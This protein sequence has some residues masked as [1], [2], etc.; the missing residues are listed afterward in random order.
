AK[1]VIA[2]RK[3]RPKAAALV[4]QVNKVT[5]GN[6]NSCSEPLQTM[7]KIGCCV[8][9]LTLTARQSYW[10]FSCRAHKLQQ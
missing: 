10:W 1:L 3:V 2:S 6:R 5:N 4:N 8:L 9:S 7:A